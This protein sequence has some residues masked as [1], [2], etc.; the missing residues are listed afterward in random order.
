MQEKIWRQ[1]PNPDRLMPP[2]GAAH[3]SLVGPECQVE[4]TPGGVL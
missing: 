2:S 4:F 1:D 3:G